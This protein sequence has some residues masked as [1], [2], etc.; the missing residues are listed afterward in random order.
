MRQ[1]HLA[2]QVQLPAWLIAKP[3]ADRLQTHASTQH[4]AREQP[5][6]PNKHSDLY[7]R[8]DHISLVESA[9]EEQTDTAKKQKQASNSQELFYNSYSS[10]P[11]Q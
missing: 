4:T 1:T 6:Q 11:G 9:V 7:N 8:R 3:E 2:P 10:I 5:Q